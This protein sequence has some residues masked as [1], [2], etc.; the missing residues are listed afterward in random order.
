MKKFVL[1]GLACL[2]LISFESFGGLNGANLA[3]ARPGSSKAVG[4]AKTKLRQNTTS[5]LKIISL[6]AEPRRQVRFNPVV[7]SKES[8]SMISDFKTLTSGSPSDYALQTSIKMDLTVNKV[9]PN[10]DINYGY[11]YSDA[12][13]TPD[14]SKTANKKFKTLVGTKGNV[15]V[16]ANGTTK[17]HQLQLSPSID[18]TLKSSMGKMTKDLEQFVMVLPSSPLGVGAKWTLQQPF[19]VNGLTINQ[20]A[21]YEVVEIDRQGMKIKYTINQRGGN[22]SL[23]TTRGKNKNIDTMTLKSVGSGETVLQFDRLMPIQSTLDMT[24]D[25]EVVTNSPGKKPVSYKSKFFFGMN[26]KSLTPSPASP[27]S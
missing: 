22:R 20:Q 12:G 5:Q 7:N 2:S 14:L 8:I 15:L 24:S 3:I 1:T 13:M 23:S 26:L 9:L 10:G 25:V 19:T 6:G 18:P 21:T 16:G 4:N 17:K 11:I 27:T